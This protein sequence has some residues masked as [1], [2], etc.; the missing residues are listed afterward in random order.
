MTRMTTLLNYE[1]NSHC[2]FDYN[3]QVLG[4]S[5]SSPSSLERVGDCVD[6]LCGLCW[7]F[8]SFC[9]R[10]NRV[11]KPIFFDE[12]LMALIFVFVCFVWMCDSVRLSLYV[13]GCVCYVLLY[14]IYM[15]MVA[16]WGGLKREKREP[17]VSW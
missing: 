8:W 4:S 6:Y 3:H 1:D 16:V 13:G 7:I 17:L 2:L 14:I 10:G 9:G 5:L 12:Q 11:G 15:Y